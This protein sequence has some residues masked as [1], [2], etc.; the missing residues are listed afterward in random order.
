MKIGF[1]IG[2]V[3]SKYPNEMKEFMDYI[4]NRDYPDRI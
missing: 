3:I 2:G 1:D 4:W